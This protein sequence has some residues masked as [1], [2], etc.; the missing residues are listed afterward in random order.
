M[1]DD[2]HEA[3]LSHVVQAAQAGRGAGDCGRVGGYQAAV[4]GGEGG[5]FAFLCVAG[6]DRFE[7]GVVD[8]VGAVVAVDEALR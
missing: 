5:V 6:A 2:G 8:E 4:V 7:G 3:R 1:Q